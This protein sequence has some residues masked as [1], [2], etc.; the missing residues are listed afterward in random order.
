MVGGKVGGKVGR[1]GGS[2]VLVVLVVDEVVMTRSQAPVTRSRLKPD[3][4]SQR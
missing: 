2:V 4:Q 1:G 3:A